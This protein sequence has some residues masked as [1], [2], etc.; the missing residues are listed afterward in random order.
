MQIRDFCPD[1]LRDYLTMAGDFYGG[2]A[3]LFPV[4][5]TQLELTFRQSIQKN[6]LMRGLLIEEDGKTAGY[7]LL[8]FYWSC[9][10]GGLVVQLEELYFLEEFRGRGL[11]KRYFQ[12][13]FDQYPQAARFRLEVCEKNPRAKALYER[14]GFEVLPYIQMTRANPR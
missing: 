6:P 13:I 12:W 2:D 14:L 4:S 3:T 10:A 5:R 7:G 8:A 1:D 11:G 9:E